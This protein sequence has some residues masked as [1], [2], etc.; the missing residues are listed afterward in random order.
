[1][2]AMDPIAKPVCPT[3]SDH[4]GARTGVWVLD[5]IDPAA[6][7]RIRK[8]IGR[9]P[10]GSQ[11]ADGSADTARG[12]AGS[13]GTASAHS[14]S[15]PPATNAR[16]LEMEPCVTDAPP[17]G[18]GGV[19]EEAPEHPGPEA[20]EGAAPGAD[21]DAAIRFDIAAVKR[22]IEE[23][24]SESIDVPALA[25]EVNLT[26][27]HFTRIFRDIEGVPPWTYVLERRVR[28]ALELLDRGVPPSQVALDTG[29]CDQSHLTRVFRRFTGTTPGEYRRERTIVQDAAG[30]S[31]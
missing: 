1:M 8:I 12:E 24:L 6:V 29:F 25:R 28:R 15:F 31:C 11:C 2:G 16:P 30:A 10:A 19:A 4:A 20:G 26:R 17:P 27:P 3:P 18:A 22:F 7:R 5:P 9:V 21:G 14:G 13:T 23:H